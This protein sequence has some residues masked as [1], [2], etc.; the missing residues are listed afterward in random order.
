MKK[1]EVSNPPPPIPE[2][3]QS[4]NEQDDDECCITAFTL[5]YWSYNVVMPGICYQN[6]CPS[7][8]PVTLVCHA[9]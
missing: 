1:A 4:D 6:V 3:A 2:P 7:V 5:F 9:Y 8:C